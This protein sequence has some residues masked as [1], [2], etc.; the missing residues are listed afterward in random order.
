MTTMTD[1]LSTDQ[2]DAQQDPDGLLTISEA[3]TKFGVSTATLRRWVGERWI[4][5]YRFPGAHGGVPM[6]RLHPDDVRAFRDRHR[7]DPVNFDEEEG[8]R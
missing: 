5:H 1:S 7:V 8:P 2:T 6:I 4:R 3:S